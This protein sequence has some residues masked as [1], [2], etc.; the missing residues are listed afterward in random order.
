VSSTADYVKAKKRSRKTMYLSFDE[1][2]VWYQKKVKLM[3]WDEAPPLLEDRYSLLD[4]LVFGG[5]MCSLLNNADRVRMA[6]LAQLVNVIA[7]IFT[8][9]GG[10][11]IRQTIYHPFQQVARYGVGAVLR[12]IVH[13]GQQE[14]KSYGEVPMLQSAATYD[15]ETG[16]IALFVLNTHQ[17]Q[18]LS[19]ET[20]FRSFGPVRCVEHS[21][22]DGDDL[23]AIND[24][25]NP[26]RV[27]PRQVAIP[28][29]TE[30]SFTV[31][32]PKLSW[33]VLRFERTGK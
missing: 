8:E 11:A 24:F 19:L 13:C 21:V 7:P 25:A 33:N 22:M 14:T 31:E 5:L 20:D 23:D 10:S 18:S 2:N 28:Q 27:S 9:K 12:P 16:S 30:S 4:S 29:G 1:W 6:C 26:N 32:L 3:P 15:E 17:E